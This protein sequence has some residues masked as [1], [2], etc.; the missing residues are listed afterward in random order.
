VV[1]ET[2]NKPVPVMIAPVEWVGLAE[3]CVNAPPLKV[4]FPE[5]VEAKFKCKVPELIVVLPQ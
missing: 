2:F 4:T 1:E 3:I 5:S